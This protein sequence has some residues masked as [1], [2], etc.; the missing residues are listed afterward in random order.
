MSTM[1]IGR[2]ANL[3]PSLRKALEEDNA[4]SEIETRGV[5]A[6][7]VLWDVANGHSGQCRFIAAFHFGVRLRSK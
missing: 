2:A 4:R 1:Q 6:L 7:R 5:E 3:P